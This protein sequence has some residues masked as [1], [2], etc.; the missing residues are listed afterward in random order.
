VQVEVRNGTPRRKLDCMGERQ[1]WALAKI[2]G[3][4]C[5]HVRLRGWI[6]GQASSLLRDQAREPLSGAGSGGGGGGGAG[7]VAV[8]GNGQSRV[9]DDP[10]M[11]IFNPDTGARGLDNRAVVKILVRGLVKNRRRTLLRNASK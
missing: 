6:A 9:R 5:L 2:H 11:V 3:S 4:A 7:V 10:E 1:A 8:D